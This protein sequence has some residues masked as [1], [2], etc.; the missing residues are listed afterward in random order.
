MRTQLNSNCIV[1]QWLFIWNWTKH[2][3]ISI[4][5]SLFSFRFQSTNVASISMRFFFLDFV[6]NRQRF[7]SSF[8]LPPFNAD[9]IILYFNKDTRIGHD[10]D[11]MRLI[12]NQ[13]QIYR[14]ILIDTVLCSPQEKSIDNILTGNVMHFEESIEIE[15]QRLLP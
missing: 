7:F 5:I 8:D 1:L 14:W 15:L 3:Y 9:K 10:F 2:I 13:F 4:I 12:S 11:L 6:E